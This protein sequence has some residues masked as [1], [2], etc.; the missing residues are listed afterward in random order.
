MF[1]Y[2]ILKEVILGFK[3]YNPIKVLIFGRG[4]SGKTTIVSHIINYLKQDVSYKFLDAYSSKEAYKIL[5]KPCNTI[6]KCLLVLDDIEEFK[7]SSL[8]NTTIS[9]LSTSSKI[10]IVLKNNIKYDYIYYI[11]GLN[12]RLVTINELLNILVARNKQ[13]KN[14]ST[15]FIDNIDLTHLQD[16]QLNDDDEYAYLHD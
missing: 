14:N 10:D 11:D 13:R 1:N 6:L 16:I 2:E 8:K 3:M 4:F 12:L 5:N 9:F 15:D 7:F